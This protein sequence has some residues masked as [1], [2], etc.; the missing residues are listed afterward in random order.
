[1]DFD[2]RI[3]NLTPM[4]VRCLPMDDRH[5]RAVLV[6]I[7]KIT[8][9]LSR[10]GVARIAADPAPIRHRDEPF[11]GAPYA[12]IKYPS[13]WYDEKPGTDVIVIG[14]AIPPEGSLI[15]EMDVS[16]RVGRLFKAVRV[17]G[18]RVFQGAV[19]SGVAPGPAQRLGPTPIRYE[20]AQGGV[21]DED[22]EH[23]AYD[24]KNP[25][26]IGFVEVRKKRVGSAA[27]RLSV[28]LSVADPGREPAGFGVIAAHWS[29]RIELAGTR[30]DAWRRKRA[31]VPPLDFDP[32]HHAAAHPDLY[33]ASPLR[34]DEPVE[35]VGMTP[36]G[37]FRF[38]LPDVEPR[39]LSR[40][41]GAARVHES[42]LDTMLIDADAR[43]VELTW[44]ISLPMPRKVQRLDKIYVSA[45]NEFPP[46][47]REAPF[48]DAKSPEAA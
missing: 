8:Y 34:P 10:T 5:G 6:T 25:S 7:A 18:V 38:K 12:S 45:L 27:P 26:G 28:P 43:R 1:M 15:T 24:P 14:T 42:H 32:R 19:F 21:D 3:E 29:P 23:V 41:D 48:P 17:H 46:S 31:P 47:I 13:D 2:G 11:D 16:V 30:D 36:E 20:L 33:S 44:R 39:F 4:E 9:V 37:V 40:L 35:L 22:P